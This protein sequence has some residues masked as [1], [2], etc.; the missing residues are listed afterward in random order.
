MSTRDRFPSPARD[1]ADAYASHY[2]ERDLLTAPRS[3]ESVISR[4]PDSPEAE[5]S[6]SQ[7]HNIA[8]LVVP[9]NDLM[10][11]CIDLAVRHLKSD[12][13]DPASVDAP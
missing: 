2:S 3:Y 11:A 8:S 7:I 12:H 1:Y 10:T 5:Y 6:H 4:H 9:R 13:D